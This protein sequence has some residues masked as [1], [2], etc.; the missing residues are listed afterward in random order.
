MV[1]H[2]NSCANGP[3]SIANCWITISAPPRCKDT[4][5]LP[6]QINEETSVLMANALAKVKTDRR[7]YRENGTKA[8]MGDGR[9][10]PKLLILKGTVG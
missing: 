6:D 4:L 8:W 7:T 3:C 10:A 5:A 1:I 2:G 9:L